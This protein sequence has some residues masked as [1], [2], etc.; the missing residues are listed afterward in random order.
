MLKKATLDASGSAEKAAPSVNMQMLGIV[1]LS[2]T[3]GAIGQ[4]VLKA[5]L[6][7]MGRLELSFQTLVNMALNP[8]LLLGLCIYAV[9]AAFWLLVLTKADLSFAYPF[10]SLT[11]IVVL[12]GGAW[13]FHDQITFTRLIG[14]GVTILGLLIIARSE[15]H[16]AHTRKRPASE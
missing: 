2:V 3:I 7:R 4:L 8:L 16:Q 1:L 13:L 11:Y 9:S 12:L 14:F 5:A 6:N 15:H 10:L